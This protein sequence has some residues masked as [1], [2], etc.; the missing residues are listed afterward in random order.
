MSV[1]ILFGTQSIFKIVDDPRHVRRKFRIEL[2]VFSRS[3]VNEAEGLGMEGL[4]VQ[5]PY[6]SLEVR[7]RDGRQSAAPA[8]DLVPHQRVARL[9]K[10][11]PDL[12]GTPGFQAKAE[13]RYAGIAVQYPPVGNRLPAP[14]G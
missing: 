5:F 6:K 8:V 9:G 7:V 14:A 1:V 3:R 13:V 2:Q 4:A 12:V 10:M 11:D